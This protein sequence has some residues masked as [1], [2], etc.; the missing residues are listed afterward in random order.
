MSVIHRFLTRAMHGMS[1]WLC[2]VRANVLEK[3]QLLNCIIIILGIRE[4]LVKDM[5]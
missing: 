5:K 1:Y 4:K 3:R 2:Y